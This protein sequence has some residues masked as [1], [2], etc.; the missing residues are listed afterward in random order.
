[1]SIKGIDG[2]IMVARTAEVSQN[3]NLANA[4]RGEIH[5]DQVA[6]QGQ[7]EDLHE[8][9]TV[10]RSEEPEQ[11]G[12]QQEDRRSDPGDRRRHRDRRKDGEKDDAAELSAGFG[13]SHKIDIKI[14]RY[15]SSASAGGPTG[16]APAPTTMLQSLEQWSPS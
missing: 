13:E 4:R 8:T 14:Q 10:S 7:A 12:I 6:L 5:Q 1:M 16:Q 3:Q 11:V 9:Q 2:Q 15:E